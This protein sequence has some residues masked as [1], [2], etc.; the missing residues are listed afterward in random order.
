MEVRTSR[1]WYLYPSSNCHADHG[2]RHRS[3]LAHRLSLEHCPTRHPVVIPERLRRQ[4]RQ[5]IQIPCFAPAK[6]QLW[7]CQL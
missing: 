2:P 3:Y 1:A 5:V 4:P 6:R 7:E